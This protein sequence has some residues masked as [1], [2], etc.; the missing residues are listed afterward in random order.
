MSRIVTIVIT[1]LTGAMKAWVCT[2]NK[3]KKFKIKVKNF[4]EQQNNEKGVK[5]DE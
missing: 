5:N 2:W 1:I 4:N 3:G